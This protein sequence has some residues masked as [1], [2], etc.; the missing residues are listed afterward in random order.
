MLY[1]INREAFKWYA[2]ILWGWDEKFQ[3]N[4]F[5]NHLNIQNV[6]VIMINE[7]PV[8]FFSIGYLADR[9]IIET[10]AIIL[11]YQSKGIGTKIIQKTIRCS[12][13]RNLLVYLRV[14]KINVRAKQL[15][16]R[17]GFQQYDE[18]DTHFC[19]VRVPNS[20]HQ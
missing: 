19:Y 13:E 4:Y 3:R 9:I 8:G 17:F 7:N 11:K 12:E 10:I 20:I 15:Y 16:K 1:R 5:K 18:D 6:C 2:E 14:A